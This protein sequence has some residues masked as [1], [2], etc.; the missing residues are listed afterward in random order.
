MRLARASEGYRKLDRSHQ[1]TLP[2]VSFLL[3]CVFGWF[4]GCSLI[5]PCAI[6]PRVRPTRYNLEGDEIVQTANSSYPKFPGTFTY[7]AACAVSNAGGLWVA[8]PLW[9]GG[10]INSSA[11]AFYSALPTTPMAPG[12]FSES[13][14]G[15]Y[16]FWASIRASKYVCVGSM[17]SPSLSP[18][19]DG[20]GGECK[21]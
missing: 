14:R 3:D 4:V 9:W 8:W 11:V 15:S 2:S 6:H 19:A 16:W 12:V 7:A 18:P 21:D 17:S 20:G 1:I 10:S 13:Y 5:T